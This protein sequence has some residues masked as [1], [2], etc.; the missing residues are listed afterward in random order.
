MIIS[1]TGE[2][3]SNLYMLG[4]AS[5]PVYLLDGDAPAIFDA[6]FCY[7]GR[8]YAAAIRAVLGPRQPAYCFLSHSHFDHCGAVAI[9]KR[10]FP[11]MKIVASRQ[12]AENLRRPHALT[13]IAELSRGALGMIRRNA[14]DLEESDHFEPF[15]VDIEAR[16]GERFQISAQTVIEIVDTPGHTRDCISFHVPRQRIL[17]CSEAAG[18]A[19]PTGYIV[20]DCLVDYDMY[21]ASMRKLARLDPDVICLGHRYAFTGE[22]ARQYMSRS[23]AFCRDFRDRIERSWQEERGDMQRVLAHI[24]AFEYDDKQEPKQPEAAYMINLKARV[25][26]VLKHLEKNRKIAIRES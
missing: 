2:I 12:A 17:L 10:C 9:L 14:M 13:L 23:M 5:V 11:E 21:Y 16:E 8:H 7:L 25:R 19:D 20:S 18:I 6:G 4:Y 22:D 3:C 15:E 24:R 26:A 1:E